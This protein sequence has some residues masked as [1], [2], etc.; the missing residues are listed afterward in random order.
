MT[1]EI[2]PS[3]NGSIRN[4]H[5][6]CKKVQ[7]EFLGFSLGLIHIRFGWYHY[8]TC[9]SYTRVEFVRNLVF[10]MRCTSMPWKDVPHSKTQPENLRENKPGY[11]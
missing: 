10:E 11:R 8:F 6:T 7:L 1:I 9:N 2:S 5:G 3:Q 4:M